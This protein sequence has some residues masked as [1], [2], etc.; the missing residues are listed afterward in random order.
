[1]VARSNAQVVDHT[2]LIA[3]NSAPEL[4]GIQRLRENHWKVVLWELIVFQR[5]S[6][7][8]LQKVS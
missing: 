6:E 1:M 5:K 3:D 8:K 2:V 7:F 4:P